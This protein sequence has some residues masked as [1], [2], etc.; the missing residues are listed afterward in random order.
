M[1]VGWSMLDLPVSVPRA[2]PQNRRCFFNRFLSLCTAVLPR[3]A[4]L[5]ELLFALFLTVLAIGSRVEKGHKSPRS[6]ICHT[7]HAKRRVRA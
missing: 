1:L 5:V 3:R 4:I 2:V 6:R 7:R